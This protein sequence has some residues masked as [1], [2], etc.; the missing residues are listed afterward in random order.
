MSLAECTG[1]IRDKVGTDSGLGATLKFDL[2]PDGV[3]FVDAASVPN[4]VDNTDRPAD[5]TIRIA[6]AD[7][8]AMM[9]GTM[10]P[11]T[12]FLMGKVKVEG[13][14]SVAMRLPQVV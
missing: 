3:I 11:A 5:C 6:L 2:G 14:M 10:D 1:A 8:A 12:A 7:L 9:A 13:D 4:S